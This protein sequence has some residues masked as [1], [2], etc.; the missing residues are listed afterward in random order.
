MLW[1][2]RRKDRLPVIIHLLYSMNPSLGTNTSGCGTC[3]ISK[4][5]IG[6]HNQFTLHIGIDTYNVSGSGKYLYH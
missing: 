4:Y 2:S 1:L 5:S 6:K 3:Q